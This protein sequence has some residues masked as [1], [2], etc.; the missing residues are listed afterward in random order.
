VCTQAG[1]EYSDVSYSVPDDVGDENVEEED[2]DDELDD[3]T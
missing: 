1:G 2:D 3:S